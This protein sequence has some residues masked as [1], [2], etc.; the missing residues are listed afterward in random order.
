MRFISYDPGHTTGWAIFENDTLIS[1]GESV[2]WK[3]IRHQLTEV[4][5]EYDFILFEEFKLFPWKAKHKVWDTF[6]EIEVIGVI[7]ELA[8]YNGIKVVSQIPAQKDFF[9]NDKLDR[10]YGKIQSGHAKDAVRHGL[11]YLTFGEGKK[12]GY[13][14]DILRRVKKD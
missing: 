2:D 5:G 6:L 12:L 9:S 13:S 4:E 8:W 10:I 3:D 7:K 11:V 1:A 14:Q